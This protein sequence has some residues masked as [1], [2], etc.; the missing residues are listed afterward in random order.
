MG[1]CSFLGVCVW[2]M[3]VC[4][5]EK[6]WQERKAGCR[7]RKGL[8]YKSCSQ[9][10]QEPKLGC[11]CVS[12]VAENLRLTK[13][14]VP[15]LWESRHA[16]DRQAIGG[17]FSTSYML[18][19]FHVWGQVLCNLHGAGKSGS[20]AV[21]PH[22]FWLRTL[23][24]N[25]SSLRSCLRNEQRGRKVRFYF[26]C[27]VDASL[28]GKVGRGSVCETHLIPW[29]FISGIRPGYSLAFSGNG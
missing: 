18:T 7:G 21:C 1:L 3:C 12:L 4:V 10:V 19:L 16:A 8:E 9:K 22:V 6:S 17:M 2:C 26:K 29:G 14:L 24:G 20:A 11:W 28:K 27:R 13:G 15:D 23:L 25:H 5:R